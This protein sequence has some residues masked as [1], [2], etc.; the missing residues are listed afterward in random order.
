MVF[1]PSLIRIRLSCQKFISH[2][3]NGI[4][5]CLNLDHCADVAFICL[6]QNGALALHPHPKQQDEGRRGRGKGHML[7]DRQVNVGGGA[8]GRKGEEMLGTTQPLS[9]SPAMLFSPESRAQDSRL[10]FQNMTGIQ[11]Q[12]E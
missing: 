2:L 5:R 10:T 12:N 9:H 8:G 11:E 6:I 1:P 3:C 4:R 7:K